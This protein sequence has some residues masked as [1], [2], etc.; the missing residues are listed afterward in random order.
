MNKIFNAIPKEAFE[1]SLIKS[2]A[3]MLFD[4]TMWGSLVFGMSKLIETSF[5]AKLP[6]LLK[7][8]SGASYSIVAGFFMWT[9]FVVGHDCGHT[10]F[11]KFPL[12]NDFFGH[13]THGSLIVPFYPW[14]LS[15]RKH[16][17]F[18]NHVEKD[19]S[20]LWYTPERM[21]RPNEWLARLLHSLPI[22]IGLFPF[23]GWQFYLLGIQD[24]NHFFP[25]AGGRIWED[26]PLKEKVKGFFSA[27]VCGL[28]GA[29][30]YALSGFN[31]KKFALLYLAPHTMFSW[32][33]V[34]VTYLQHHGPKTQVYDD[35]TFNFVESAFETVDR[36]FG[37]GIDVLHH[38]ITDGHLAHHLFFTKIPHYNLP[39]ATN[40]VKQY[41]QDNGLFHMYRHEETQ[42]FPI[43]L[44]KYFV[45][46]GFRS[47][48]PVSKPLAT[49]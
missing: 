39:I 36:T 2:I 10:T 6:L 33:L 1:K 3:Y 31:L 28:F 19:H 40:A 30:F 49:A 45:E 32:W 34:C 43:R 17:M 26:S 46:V 44:H 47:N 37:K 13:L 23:F 22:L 27:I 29:G 42:D 21:A 12:A 16:H 38:H 35:K 5:W 20:Y 24:G 7:V 18:H 9:I 15:H 14:Q 41:L 48:S 11:S 4:Y 8:F 25:F